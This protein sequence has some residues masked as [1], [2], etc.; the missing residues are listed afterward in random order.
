[1]DYKIISSSNKKY[2]LLEYNSKYC[3]NFETVPWSKNNFSKIKFYLEKLKSLKKNT[4]VILIDASDVICINN[5]IEEFYNIFKTFNK[6]IIFGAECGGYFVFKE[7][8]INNLRKF[9]NIF[10]IKKLGFKNA[11]G[12]RW[13]KKDTILNSGLI[14]GYSESIIDFFTEVLNIEHNRKSDQI[15]IINTIIKTPNLATNISIDF[16]SQLF[17]NF[18]VFQN[19]YNIDNKTKNNLFQYKNQT[20]SPFFIHFPGLSFA[21]Q[22]QTFEKM[23]VKLDLFKFYYH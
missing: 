13:L 8:Q 6:E 9:M 14:C 5:N 20:I 11:Y 3:K 16:K 7:N 21:N 19:D 22:K 10:G 23:L 12:R 18:S 1:M 15:S 17:H 4:F 2:K